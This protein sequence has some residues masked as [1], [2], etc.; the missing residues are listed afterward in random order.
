[1][2]VLRRNLCN[3]V[4]ARAEAATGVVPS[5]RAVVVERF[6]DEIG[7]WRVCVLTPFGGR[8][9]PG[10]WHWAATARL[11]RRRCAVDLVNDG[12]A[13][14][15]PDADQPPPL[16]DLLLDPDEVEELVLGGNWRVGA[17]R[18]AFPR[19]RFAGAPHPHRRPGQRTPLWQQRLKAQSLLQVARRYPQF[20][21]VLETYRECLQ[22]VFDLPAL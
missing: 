3:G 1:M 14:H 5:D 16:S 11:A 18:L 4:S 19:E 12:I 10:R 13:L 2:R 9:L 17:L 22:D 20:P 15:F 8:T 7:D 21:I 6:R